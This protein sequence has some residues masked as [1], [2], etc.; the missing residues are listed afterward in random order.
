MKEKELRAKLGQPGHWEQVFR[1]GESVLLTADAVWPLLEGDSPGVRRIDRYCNALAT[2]WRKR[3]EG[4]LLARAGAAAGPDTPP[5]EAAMTFRVTLLRDDCFSFTID[6]TENT[7]SAPRRIRIGEAWTLPGGRPLLLREVLPPGD[8]R[9]KKLLDRVKGQIEARL[10]SG[11]SLFYQDW[12]QRLP[13]H[14]STQRFYLEESG[15][16]LFFPIRSIASS[17]EG[18]PTFPLKI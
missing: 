11:E 12:P 17:L 9:K 5:W 3:W 18:F 6:I 7:G 1:D 8:A 16:V 15:P 4:P 14:L 2:R 13:A 10:N